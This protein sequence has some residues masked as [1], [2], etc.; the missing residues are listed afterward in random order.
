MTATNDKPN[1]PGATVATV[2]DKLSAAGAGVA[3]TNDALY[4]VIVIGAG[5]VGASLACALTRPASAQQAVPRVLLLEAAPISL[6]GAP[7]QPGFD[8]RSTVLSASSVDA[9]QNLALWPALQGDAEPISTIVVSDQGRFGTVRLT[10]AEAG[11]A[12]L[13]H[14]VENGALGRAFNSA[15]LQADTFALQS[16]VRVQRLQPIPGGMRVLLEDG[17]ALQ[18]ALVVLAEGGRSA[19][20]AQLGIVQQE[21]PYGQSAVISNIACERPH[22]GY[23]WERFTPKGPLA[24][25]PLP[26]HAGEHR[27]ALIWTHPAAKA[28]A[29]LALLEN[30]FLARLQ[31]EFGAGLGAL[32]K[33]GR[34]ALFPL[35]LSV[36]TEQVRPALVLLGNAAHTL[37]PVAGQGFN[38]ALRD[39]VA[40]A[41]HCRLA[42]AA[43]E[44]PGAMHWLRRYQQAVTPDQKLTI[45]FSHHMT[46]LFA[47]PNP[48]AALARQGGM[49]SLELFPPLRHILARQ[50]MGYRQRRMAL[51]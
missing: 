43:G 8:S 27:C 30:E 29:V 26:D 47:S 21:R 39:A 38:L 19:L 24:L 18:A 25:L 34:R 15:L 35:A 40:L 11:V 2:S 50:A 9:L 48:G 37:H 22:A 13:G 1:P 51:Q 14:V 4:D 44:S 20:A 33:A 3:A 23:A 49:L 17:T 10:A 31:R 28:E 16:G 41:R 5:M 12:A 7:Q 42:L 32:R 6:Q 46:R 36:A 45:D